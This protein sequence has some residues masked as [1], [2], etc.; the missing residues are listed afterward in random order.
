MKIEDYEKIP[1]TRRIYSF[2][3]GTMIIEKAAAGKRLGSIS[4]ES[5]NGSPLIDIDCHN[6]FGSYIRYFFISRRYGTHEVY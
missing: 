2:E 3:D 4:M 5:Y 1:A 6:D